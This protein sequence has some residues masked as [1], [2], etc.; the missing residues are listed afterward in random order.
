MTVRSCAVA[1]SACLALAGSLTSLNARSEDVAAGTAFDVKLATKVQKSVTPS[2]R[3]AKAGKIVMC[4]ELGDPPG[5]FLAEDGVTPR[6]FNIDIM[7]AVGPVMGIK[8]QVVNYPFADIFAALD[9]GKCDAVMST[10]SKSP[11]RLARY[12]F[13]SYMTIR[14]GLMVP[15]GNPLGLKTFEDLSG[16]RAAVLVS[17]TTERLLKATNEK[18][19]AQGKKPI[20]IQ[21][22]PQNT[23]VFRQLELGRVDAFVGDAMTIGYFTH[24]IKDKFEVGGLPVEP[25]TIG[26]VLRKD[27]PETENAVRKA[28]FALYDSGFVEQAA[29]RW[30]M[31]DLVALCRD[32]K[33]CS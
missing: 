12:N 28:Y 9:S 25:L 7:S 27:D 32:D 26:I 2:V 21:S 4:T 3:L 30:G 18:L 13:V 29:K 20:E 31:A 17:S 10:D 8:S 33:P 5:G 24:L 11:A 6:G 23:V 1:F 19:V 15:K 14:L 22:Y 16:H